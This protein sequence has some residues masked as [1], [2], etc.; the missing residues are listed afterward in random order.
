MQY[1]FSCE[2]LSV[3]LAHRQWWLFLMSSPHPTSVA[4]PERDGWGVGNPWDIRLVF[5]HRGTCCMGLSG[6]CRIF[7]YLAVTNLT[8]VTFL[9]YC[10]DNTH[11]E[12]D[13]APPH[14]ITHVQTACRRAAVPP[15]WALALPH[16]P[17]CIALHGSLIPTLC[18]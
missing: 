15:V 2:I 13:T 10:V 5:L 8:P 9:T 12:R 3:C 16:S 6:T 4:H 17:A 18:M 1:F 14:S 7:N 11:A